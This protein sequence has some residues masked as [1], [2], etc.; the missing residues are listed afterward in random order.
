MRY[1][2]EIYRLIKIYVS[3]IIISIEAQCFLSK[4]MLNFNVILYILFLVGNI[5]PFMSLVSVVKIR[6]KVRVILY[7]S[8]PLHSQSDSYFSHDLLMIHFI[9]ILD[10]IRASFCFLKVFILS[11]NFSWVTLLAALLLVSLLCILQA[12]LSSSIDLS[13]STTSFILSS[14]VTKLLAHD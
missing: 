7:E 10:S 13:G 8:Q 2:A 6:V 1:L 3:F 4:S 5:Y 9:A 12:S 11:L 14:G